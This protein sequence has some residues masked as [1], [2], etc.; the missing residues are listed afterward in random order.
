[1]QSADSGFSMNPILEES[2]IEGV[3]ISESRISKVTGD[4]RALVARDNGD[5]RPLPRLV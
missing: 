5:V 2:L 1:M 4:P 3:D